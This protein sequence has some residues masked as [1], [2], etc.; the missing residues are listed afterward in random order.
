MNW[1]IAGYKAW[2]AGG[3]R[4]PEAVRAATAAYRAESDPLGEFFEDRVVVDEAGEVPAA[5]LYQAYQ[6]WASQA[7]LRFP[8]TQQKLGMALEGRGFQRHKGAQG[9]R[10]WRGLRLRGLTG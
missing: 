1:A 8:L 2:R 9:A 6:Q 10:S 3:L 4:A 5:L 7:G